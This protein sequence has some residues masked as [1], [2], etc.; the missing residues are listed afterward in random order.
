MEQLCIFVV[1]FGASNL[2]MEF[3][4]FIGDN[5]SQGICFYLAL[6]WSDKSC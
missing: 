1:I 2:I 4:R 5:I 6:M 3:G